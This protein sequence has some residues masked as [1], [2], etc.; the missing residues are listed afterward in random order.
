MLSKVK[1]ACRLVKFVF[2]RLCKTAQEVV[3]ILCIHL[4]Q[5]IPYFL[6]YKPGLDYKPGVLVYI[7]IEFD[8]SALSACH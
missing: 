8:R 6:E 5:V 4:I 7:L 3:F 2:S 1:A